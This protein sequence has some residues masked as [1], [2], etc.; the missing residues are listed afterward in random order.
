VP[1]LDLTALAVAVALPVGMA[2]LG[3]IL[4]GS[5]LKEWFA[6]L[7]A[8]R[9]QLPMWAFISVGALGYVLDAVILYRLLTVVQ[10]ADGRVVALTALVVVM[11]YNELWNYAFIGRRS[12][13]A[14]WVGRLAATPRASESGDAASRETPARRATSA[15]VAVGS[16]ESENTPRA[17]CRMRSRVP[18]PPQ[19]CN[20]TRRDVSSRQVAAGFRL[21]SA[22]APARSRTPAARYHRP[23]CVRR[24]RSSRP[25]DAASRGSAN[26]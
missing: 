19:S 5:A 13:Y 26:A 14:G 22:V 17:A 18:R 2:V 3:T 6:H 1:T 16:G 23:A 10:D 11:L 7:K 4:A 9:W 24:A 15:K 25:V 20:Q 12:T 8:P 21:K